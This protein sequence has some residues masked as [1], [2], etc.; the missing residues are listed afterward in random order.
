LTRDEDDGVN[1][2]QGCRMKAARIE[3]VAHRP[4]LSLSSRVAFK[5]IES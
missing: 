2:E 1:E 5:L 3:S 4:E